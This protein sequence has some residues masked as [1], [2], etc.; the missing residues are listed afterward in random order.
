MITYNA[1]AA[2][3]THIYKDGVDL[4]MDGQCGRL[5]W[6]HPFNQIWIG[7]MDQPSVSVTRSS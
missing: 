3:P 5:T 7:K 2:T 4:A 1:A 6:M